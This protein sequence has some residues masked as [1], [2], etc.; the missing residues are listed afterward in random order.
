MC[1]VLMV[2][3]RFWKASAGLK[4]VTFFFTLLWNLDDGDSGG[5]HLDNYGPDCG[6]FLL[7]YK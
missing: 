6:P 5:T 2:C 3:A 1:K 7:L 4:H